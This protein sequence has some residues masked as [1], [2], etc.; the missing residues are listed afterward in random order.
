MYSG[1][2]DAV[3]GNH[4]G[5]LKRRKAE[6]RNEMIEDGANSNP[7]IAVVCFFGYIIIIWYYGKQSY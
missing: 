1:L 7:I 5:K 3:T 6:R 2:A 4:A